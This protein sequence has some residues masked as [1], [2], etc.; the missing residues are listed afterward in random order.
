MEPKPFKINVQDSE[1]KLLD[2][3]LALARFPDEPEGYNKGQG[4]PLADMKRV[5][6]YWRET[7]LPQWREK[8][9]K[10]LNKLPFFTLPI[11][12]DEFGTLDIHF[13]HQK[14]GKLNAVPLLFIHGWPGCF[15][16]A[17]KLLKVLGD[18]EKNGVVFDVVVP[19]LPNYG[20]S[21]GIKKV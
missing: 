2:Q 1:L 17:T 4:A 15:L 21:D 5:V 14:S 11:D 6:N 10:E 12:M 13:V 20:F 8:H 16:E 3:K 18:A 9:E 19:S 7:Y